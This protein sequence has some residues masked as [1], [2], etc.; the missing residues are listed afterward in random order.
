MSTV[1]RIF[2]I[3]TVGCCF[4]LGDAEAE[5]ARSAILLIGD[6]MGVAHVSG[7]R[8][9]QGNARDGILALDNFERVAL[10]RTYSADMMVTDS[11]A[12][13][14]ALATGRKTRYGSAGV[15]AEGNDLETVLER[16]KAAGKSV[17]IVTTARVT[18]GTPAAF[19]A[20]VRNRDDEQ[21]IAEQLLAFGEI[22]VVL[23]GGREF[24]LPKEVRDEESGRTGAREDGRNLIAE[25]AQQGYRVIQRES[26][27]RTLKDRVGNASF[28]RKVLGLFNFSKMEYVNRRDKDR[29]GEPS[30]SEMTEFALQVLSQ[31]PEGFFLLVEGALIDHA[32]HENRGRVA[33]E[34]VLAFDEAVG[35][36]WTFGRSHPETLVVATADHGTGGL[37]INGYA[38]IEVGGADLLV[39]EPIGG[40]SE[41]LSFAT[42]P[43]AKRRGG[44]AA[45]GSPW[46]RQPALHLMESAAH[47][48]EDVLAWAAGPGSEGI[49]GTMDNHEIGQ[50][51]HRALFETESD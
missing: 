44:M 30:L 14:T 18:H 5:T 15:D 1:I 35:I 41:V 36:A 48:A 49:A 22:D 9:F 50:V 42:G 16:A 23:G 7:A 27:F 10:V 37:S 17:G 43:G 29:W 47:T 45:S 13:A 32:T 3:C 26:E 4:V 21:T 6:G 11:A 19:Y 34:E 33:L 38:R 20:N 51:L 39:T 25:A 24:F 28:P 31:N 46:Y 12:A 8:I 2:I 40:H